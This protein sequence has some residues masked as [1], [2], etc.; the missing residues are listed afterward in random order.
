MSECTD[1]ILPIVFPSLYRNSRQHWNK[2]IHPLVMDAL[3]L[4]M[5]MSPD[6]FDECIRNYRKS[7][8]KYG[9]FGIEFLC[10]REKNVRQDMDSKWSRIESLARENAKSR[11]LGT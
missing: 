3:K 9:I 11:G 7:I 2:Q 8:Q 5:E 6:L 1:V 4:F 10:L